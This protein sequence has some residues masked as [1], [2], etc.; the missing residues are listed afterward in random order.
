M[1]PAEPTRLQIDVDFRAEP[2]EG[3]LRHHASGTSVDRPFRGWLGLMAAI[4][5]ARDLRP[6]QPQAAPREAG[7]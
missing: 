4:E 2:I 6:S 3:R 1:K 7:G 5:A